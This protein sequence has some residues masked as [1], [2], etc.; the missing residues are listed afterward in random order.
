MN[1]YNHLDD[2][3]IS[4]HAEG[5]FMKAIGRKLDI[6]PSVVKRVI[7]KHG[8]EFK[9]TIYRKYQ[10]DNTFFDNINSEGKAY[11]LGFLFADGN[12]SLKNNTA[13]ITLSEKDKDILKM[14]SSLIYKEEYPIKT[15]TS[16]QAPFNN[17]STINIS[18]QHLINR[19]IELGCTPAKSLTLKYP[20]ELEE[21]MQRHFIRGYFDGD[22][23]FNVKNRLFVITSTLQFCQSIQNIIEKFAKVNLYIYKYKNVYR[24]TS[25][26]RNKVEK[27]L[28]WMYEDATLFLTRKYQKYQEII[29]EPSPY[30]TNEEK[31]DFL[32]LNNNGLSSIDIAKIYNCSPRGVAKA[33][34]KIR[35]N[36]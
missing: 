29:K 23:T 34:S 21:A 22:G 18:D 24:L 28:N 14:F 20:C 19:L 31:N 25:H 4:L 12:V 5:F 3:I 13:T 6:D 16:K 11:F 27:I 2:Q 26:G 30:F 1:K 8:L 36:K 10:I 17:Y 32:L 35:N 7:L 9:T 33:L 15:R